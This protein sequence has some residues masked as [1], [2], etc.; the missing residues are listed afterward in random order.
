M[1]LPLVVAVL[2]ELLA[3]K[4]LARADNPSHAAIVEIDLAELSALALKFQ[5]HDRAV[6][7]GV[8]IAQ[9]GETVGAVGPCVFLVADADQRTVEQGDDRGDDFLAGQSGQREVTSHLL[10]KSRQRFAKRA[11]LAELGAAGMS[12]PVLMVDVL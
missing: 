10:A 5:V 2:K 4:L 11:E 6:D 8:T 9:R 1:K 12:L 7:L 3:R